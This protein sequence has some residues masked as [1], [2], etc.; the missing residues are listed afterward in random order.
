MQELGPGLAVKRFAGGPACRLVVRLSLLVVRP[1]GEA[2]LKRDTFHE[3]R[4]FLPPI[5]YRLVTLGLGGRRFN[6]I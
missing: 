1:L 2:D 4:S 5:N 3:R 6:P